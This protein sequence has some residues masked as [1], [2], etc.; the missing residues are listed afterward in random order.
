M[1][2]NSKIIIHEN[3]HA[4]AN[5]RD[6]PAVWDDLL[7]GSKRKQYLMI[8]TPYHLFEST[9]DIPFDQERYFKEFGKMFADYLPDIRRGDTK[10]VFMFS[11]FWNTCN[12]WETHKTV[13]GNFLTLDLY[14]LIYEVVRELGILDHS[15][16]TTSS[17]LVDVKMH[18][19]WPALY[20]NEPFNR[21]LADEITHSFSKVP[22]VTS[23]FNRKFF[24]LNRRTRQH[25]IYA[26]HQAAKLGMFENSYYTFH[27]FSESEFDNYYYNNELYKFSLSDDEID[28]SFL[29]YQTTE[30]II[31][32]LYNKSTDIQSN[33]ELTNLKN[34]SDKCQLEL[35]SEFNCSNNKV[36]LTEKIARSIVLGNPFIIM[37]DKESLSELHRYG[38]KT[39]S[40]FW[41][42][43]YDT[44]DNIKDRIDT[45]LA[46]ATSIEF[47]NDH[48]QDMI[49]ILEYN[50]DH[51]Y[52][53]YY[54]QQTDTFKRIIE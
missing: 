7:T 26:L 34:A 37:G 27:N 19:D 46:L 13:N 45:A 51:Y 47:R 23:G 35:V 16:F 28:L 4:K 43:S 41:D 12:K 2:P 53:N 5:Y 22:L 36:F 14:N 1:I 17:S 24:W 18:D 10:V 50:R 54:Q 3:H 15:V 44:F 33:P 8:D 49:E 52:G 38:F 40:K 30:N 39:F 29:K 11:D 21:Y 42:E 6:F 20:F 25:R 48:S 31:D 32:S 9:A